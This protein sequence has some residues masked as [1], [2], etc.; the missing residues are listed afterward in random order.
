MSFDQTPS[1][2]DCNVTMERI[3]IFDKLGTKSNQVPLEYTLPDTKKSWVTGRR[4]VAG[5]V[6]ASMCGTCGRIMLFGQNRDE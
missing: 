5:I 4:S 1:C 6:V 2:P 3:N